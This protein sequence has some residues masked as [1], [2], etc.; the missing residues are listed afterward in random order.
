[1]S[2]LVGE[3]HGFKGSC[4]VVSE[5]RPLGGLPVAERPHVPDIR[6]N[7]D[8]ASLPATGR[9]D[10]REHLVACIDHF[11]GLPARV[12]PFPYVPLA[13]DPGPRL[14]ATTQNHGVHETPREVE[15]KLRGCEV[16][17]CLVPLVK[18]GVDAP[19]KL[20]V[21]LRHRPRS[22]AQAQESA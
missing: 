12:S 8:A 6:L 14:I 22:I 16:P 13:V 1:M 18:Q 2:V 4:S 21:L 5:V 19:H 20:H 10:E 7:L 11:F 9:A 17:N 15:N 3:P